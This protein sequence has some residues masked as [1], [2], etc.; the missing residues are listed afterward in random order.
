M[1]I[2]GVSTT[3]PSSIVTVSTAVIAPL[4]SSVILEWCLTP[5]Q[6]D[7]RPALFQHW[8]GHLHTGV[9]DLDTVDPPDQD[10]DLVHT[11]YTRRSQTS[12]G[13]QHST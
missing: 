7:L 1:T 12:N 3:S 9:V 13:C 8:S 11:G 10:Q 2:A 4:A 5:R 6:W